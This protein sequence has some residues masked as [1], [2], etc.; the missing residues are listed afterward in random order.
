MAD[1]HKGYP[2]PSSQ[3]S[4]VAVKIMNQLK[5]KK[6]N[7]P[8]KTMGEALMLTHTLS[9]ELN[10]RV[11]STFPL[12]IDFQHFFHISNYIGVKG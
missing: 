9:L 1:W 4:K 2:W 11:R 10:C 7:L 12:T 8:K 6:G 3:L 5:T